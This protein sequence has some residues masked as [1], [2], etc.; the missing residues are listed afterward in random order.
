MKS[1]LF[2]CC[3][4]IVWLATL[5]VLLPLIVLLI[6][7]FTERWAWPE[8]VPQVFSLR[9]LR[10]VLGRQALMILHS[11]I[12]L[13]ATAALIAVAVGLMTA[14]AIV[15]TNFRDKNCCCLLPC[16]PLLYRLPS[17]V[18]EFICC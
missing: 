4:G 6:W 10:E 3:E 13:S 5:G 15:F 17:L 9:G 7:C 12:L 11:S 1:K 14:R 8:L 18:W 2:L 16:C